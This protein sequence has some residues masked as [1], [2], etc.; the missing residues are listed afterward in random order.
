ML[1]IETLERG[2][3]V[4]LDDDEGEVVA[5]DVDANEITVDVT[6]DDGRIDRIT[7]DCDE[8]WLTFVR[9]PS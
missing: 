1:D 7:V 9:D 6:L 4:R 5:I 3:I 2:D 8:S